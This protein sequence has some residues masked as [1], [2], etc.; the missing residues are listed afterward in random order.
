MAAMSTVYAGMTSAINPPM[1]VA[2]ATAFPTAGIGGQYYNEPSFEVPVY[3]DDARR[4][5]NWQMLDAW[6]QLSLNYAIG[7]GVAAGLVWATIIY[8]LA[9]TPSRKRS[10]AFHSFLLAG[11]VFMLI[12]L[13]MD[14]ISIATPGLSTSSAYVVLTRDISSSIWTTQYTAVY[15]TTRVAN[16]LAFVF[17][18]ICL[19]LQAKTLMTGLKVR[20][21]TIYYVLLTYLAL[22]SLAVL[23]ASM[24]YWIYQIT[25]IHDDITYPIFLQQMLRNIYLIVY[26]ISIGSF[27]VINVCSVVNIIWRRPSSVITPHNAYHSA[28]NLLGLLGAQS[29]IVPLIFCILQLVYTGNTMTL[30]ATIILPSV[31]LILPLGSLFMTVRSTDQK[32]EQEEEAINMSPQ[33]PM[34]SP[35]K[36]DAHKSPSLTACTVTGSEPSLFMLDDATVRE[37]PTKNASNSAELDLH[38]IDWERGVVKNQETDSILHHKASHTDD[39]ETLEV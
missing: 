39:K 11:L 3:S 6:N 22:T 9:L 25:V 1:P 31:Y 13:M 16:W 36:M 26:A 23:I 29:F 24:V 28:L 35:M 19:W 32:K 18:S 27:S 34:F 30:P 37:I 38:I 10:T 15:A 12:H 33:K 5:L 4:T 2:Q 20:F 8:V 7:E 17:A 21:P 14:L